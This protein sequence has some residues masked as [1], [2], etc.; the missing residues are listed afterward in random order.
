M[1]HCSTQWK[2]DVVNSYVKMLRKCK[3]CPDAHLRATD[4]QCH[5]CTVLIG[6]DYKTR[7][8]ISIRQSRT[9][10]TPQYEQWMA[11]ALISGV[12]PRCINHFS[13]A[14]NGFPL[15]NALALD[16]AHPEFQQRRRARPTEGGAHVR[17][18]SSPA[19]AQSSR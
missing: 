2:R 7:V 8:N 1:F 9:F 16:F 13:L 6:R 12:L 14:E 19:A 15:V 3:N 18:G 5:A 4:F 11:P 17:A 10:P